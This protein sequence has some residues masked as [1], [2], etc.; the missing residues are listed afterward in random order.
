M[1]TRMAVI[2]ALVAGAITVGAVLPA[3]AQD[4]G[5][6]TREA[7]AEAEAWQRGAGMRGVYR[8]GFAADLAEELG[9]DVDEVAAAIEKVATTHREAL[10]ASRT[11]RL[12][13]RLDAAV[14]AGRMTREEADAMLEAHAAGERPLRGAG[15]GPREGF[16]LGEGPCQRGEGA[17][18]RGGRGG[19][20]GRAMLDW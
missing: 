7:T 14:D 15:S 10:R 8:E 20:N 11:E 16:G 6:T 1:T 13:E 9:L 17:A 5:D 3:L 2:G 18:G 4:E 12:Q 19:M